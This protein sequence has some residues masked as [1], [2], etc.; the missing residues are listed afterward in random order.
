MTYRRE[1]IEVKQFEFEDISV[2][3]QSVLT[4]TITKGDVETFAALTGDFNPLHVDE[5]FAST[6][7]FHKPVVHG[8]LSA[9][10]ISTMIGTQLPGSG[11]LWTSQ[12]L[13]FLR[14][15]FQGDTI[16]VVSTV[17]QKSESSRML[18]LATSITNQHGQELIKGTSTVKALPKKKEVTRM[19]TSF[20]PRTVFVSGAAKGIGAAIAEALAIEGHRVIIN[21]YSS[22]SQ[23]RALE[24]RLQDQGMTVVAVRGDVSSLSEVESMLKALP[25]E[26]SQIDDC[27]HCAAPNPAPVPFASL[28]WESFRK[29]L[30][31]QVGGAFNCANSGSFI[32]V[33]SIFAEGTPPVQQSAYITAKAALAAFARSLAVE[34]GP[35]GI[36]VNVIAPGMTQTDMLATIP[37][38]TKM[39]AKM[40][41]PLRRLAE[42]SDVAEVA[43]F[44][45]GRGGA[46]ISGETIKVCGGIVM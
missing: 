43:R 45:V 33:G 28:D 40:S 18:V 13:E 31:V 4:H 34:Y 15:A 22:E 42:P 17:T 8:M 26:F 1:E 23:A 14:P 10:F 36:R 20:E 44:L 24:Q 6:T 38:K 30:E 29:H 35:K 46:H 21:Y 2:G 32:F 3:H 7:M 25:P 19:N 12:S 5:A 11:A 41:T 16:T 27:I 39:L 9:S 37:D